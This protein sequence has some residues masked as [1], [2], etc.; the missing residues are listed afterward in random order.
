[1]ERREKVVVR[2]GRGIGGDRYPHGPGHWSAHRCDD[3]TLVAAEEVEAAAAVLGTPIE[4]RLLRRNLVTEGVDPDS[5]VGRRFRMG[6][7]EVVGVRPCHPCTYLEELLGLPGLRAALNGR[8]GLRVAVL[9]P[10]VIRAGDAVVTGR[11]PAGP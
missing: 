5:L 9:G 6:T 8:G 11:P 1:M 3:L 2:P 7:A 10:G 4:P